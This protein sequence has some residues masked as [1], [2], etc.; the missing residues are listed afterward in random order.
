MECRTDG[1]E[2][3]IRISDKGVGIADVNA[4]VQP[5]F[6]TGPEDERSGM[7]FTIMQ[8]FMDD[9]SVQSNPGEGTLVCMSKRFEPEVEN[10]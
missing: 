3:H 5:F 6:T 10:A 4:A 7:G 8:T 9:F 2:L 1:C